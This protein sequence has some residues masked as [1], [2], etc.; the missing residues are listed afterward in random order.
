[1][2]KEVKGETAL[3]DNRTLDNTVLRV[4]VLVFTIPSP[5]PNSS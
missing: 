2:V 4:N 1:M 5:K 3:C